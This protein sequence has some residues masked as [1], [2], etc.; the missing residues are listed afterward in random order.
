MWEKGKISKMDNEKGYR[1]N[2]ANIKK[3]IGGHYEVFTAIRKNSDEIKIP[4]KGIQKL[5]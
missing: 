5:T 4:R 2:T 1:A 3:I